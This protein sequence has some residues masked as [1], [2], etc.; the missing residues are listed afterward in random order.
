M[1]KVDAII[2]VRSVLDKWNLRST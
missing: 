1:L 2:Y